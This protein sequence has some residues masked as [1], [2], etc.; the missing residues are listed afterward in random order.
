M[1]PQ[2]QVLKRLDAAFQTFFA[3]AKAAKKPGYP[4]FK[5][6]GDEPGIRFPDRKQFKLD[7]A[8]G[9]LQLPKLGWVRMRMSREVAGELR[10]ASVTREGNRWYVAIQTLEPLVRSPTC[11]TMGT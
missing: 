10:N 9:R 6:R 4:R 7:A 11:K 8:N 2:Q 1:H 3:N 5:K